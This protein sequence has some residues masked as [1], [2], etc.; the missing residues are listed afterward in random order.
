MFDIKYI[1][2]VTPKN[3]K[4]YQQSFLD[5]RRAIRFSITHSDEN[6]FIHVEYE[7]E[8]GISKYRTQDGVE[9]VKEIIHTKTERYTLVDGVKN[10]EHVQFYPSGQIM[11]RTHYSAGE[12]HGQ[13]VEY[14]EEGKVMSVS[15]YIRGMGDQ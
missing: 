10:G 6:P 3:G 9:H 5:V 7:I 1:V 2:S 4:T 8:Q 13:M 14:S 15:R 11:S 12:I